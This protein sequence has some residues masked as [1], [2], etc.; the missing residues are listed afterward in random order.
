MM[1][2]EENRKYLFD[3]PQNVRHL[4]TGLYIICG[5]LFAADFVLERH[6]YTALEKIPNFYSLYGFFSYLILLAISLVL[7]ALIKRKE[8]YYDE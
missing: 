6:A 8:N 4:M 1:S 5:L 7:R 3:N 2:D